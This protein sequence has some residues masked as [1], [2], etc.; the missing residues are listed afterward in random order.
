MARARILILVVVSGLMSACAGMQHSLQPEDAASIKDRLYTYSKTVDLD[1]QG[2]KRAA[3]EDIAG[4]AMGLCYLPRG[5]VET[6]RLRN[7]EFFVS[8]FY[9]ALIEEHFALQALR[10]RGDG[11]VLETICQR[12]VTVAKVFP[13]SSD[14]SLLLWEKYL[15]R[16]YLEQV[17][18]TEDPSIVQIGLA[19]RDN[20]REIWVAGPE[21]KKRMQE[22]WLRVE[23]S[24][25]AE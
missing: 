19:G 1:M 2:S 25:S 22:A 12:L 9:S 4:T 14:P 16:M 18:R 7:E 8:S 5:P 3:L 21:E 11:C 17:V 6:A 13:I 15:V 23:R 20:I 24:R 10:K